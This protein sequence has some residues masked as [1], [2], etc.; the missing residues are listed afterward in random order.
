MGRNI[1]E[2][3]FGGGYVQPINQKLKG[4]A[5]EAALARI[6]T[7]WTGHEFVRVP[8]SGGLRWKNSV[9]VCGDLI[10]TDK[11]FDFPFSIETKHL[12]SIGIDYR[13]ISVKNKI[14]L[15]RNS[16][17]Y[18]I[19][20]QAQMDADRSFKEPM[21]VIRQN[22]M[23]IDEYIVFFHISIERVIINKFLYENTVLYERRELWGDHKYLKGYLLSDLIKIDINTL[24]KWII[25]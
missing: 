15:R 3:L 8:R 21:L 25:E 16:V 10:S 17:I 23:P 2:D 19:F 18:S 5:N 22:F 14:P 7:E 20:N 24:I 12:N 13:N 11:N 9:N 1:K 6:M 4:N